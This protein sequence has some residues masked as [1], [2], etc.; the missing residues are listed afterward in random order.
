MIVIGKQSIFV[1]VGLLVSCVS[2]GNTDTYCYDDPYY[3]YQG[4]DCEDIAA[5]DLCDVAL[6]N[7]DVIGEV[8]CPV[9][10]DKCYTKHDESYLIVTKDCFDYDES[11]E[12]TYANIDPEGHD[13][14]AIFPIDEVDYENTPDLWKWLCKGG[15]EGHYCKCYSGKI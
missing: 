15:H 7:L 1:T 3:Y 12:A 9:S 4:K 10:C 14:V 2:A 6:G 11:I 13:A 8:Y 5:K